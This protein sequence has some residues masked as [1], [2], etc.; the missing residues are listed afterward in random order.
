MNFSKPR[1]LIG[2]VSAIAI[3]F[4]LTGCV[5]TASSEVDTTGELTPISLGF[6]WNGGAGSDPHDTGAFGYAEYLGEAE[7]ILEQNGYT[8]DRHVGFNNGPP[9]VQALQS[10]DITIGSL[11]DVPAVQARGNGQDIRAISVRKPSS[12]IWVLSND[13]AIS[14]IDDLTGHTI[15][16]QFGS[17]FDK[18]GRAILERHNI[19]DDVELVNLVF[20]DALPALQQGRISAV[21]LP[22]NV[23]A[24]WLESNDFT[25]VS[26]AEDD[27]PDLLSTSVSVV[28]EEFLSENPDFPSVFWEIEQAG[29][30]AIRDDLDSYIKWVAETQKVSEESVRSSS[31]WQYSDERINPEGLQT[32]QKTQD[33]LLAQG[34]IRDSFN[35]DEWVVQ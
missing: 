16:L 17:N 15:G 10:G 19:S 4:V 34:I 3:S 9:V 14:D 24:V 30:S 28:S 31:T 13:P 2:T 11:G 18:Y 33:F 5:S 6:P 21:A 27:D 8:F 12:G 22:A 7:S 20:A 1:A 35:I 25:V 29:I 23:A 26:K 32:L